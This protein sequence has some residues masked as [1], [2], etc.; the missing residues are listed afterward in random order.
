M[1]LGLHFG[2]LSQELSDRYVSNAHFDKVYHA[3][4]PCLHL[5][6]FTEGFIWGTSSCHRKNKEEQVAMLYN[7]L[8]GNSQ[9]GS[10][11]SERVQSNLAM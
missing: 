4:E 2:G 5:G 8:N 10:N 6:A 3:S 1:E 9:V 11:I 7:S